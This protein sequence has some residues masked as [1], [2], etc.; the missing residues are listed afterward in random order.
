MAERIDAHK[1]KER[2]A[3]GLKRLASDRS[4]CPRN[5]QLIADFL[6]DGELGKT[7]KRRAKKKL[8]PARCIKYLDTLRLLGAW[9]EKPFDEATQKDMEVLILK[10]EHDD[11]CRKDGR[12]YTAQTKVDFK[13]ALRKFY[14]WLW[15]NNETTPEIVSWFDTHVAV[16][17][18]PAL[19]R[20]EI[21]SM[22][23]HT[24]GSREKAALMVLFD[25]GARAE[26]FLNI[27]LQHVT[28][29]DSYYVLRI[30]HSKTKPRT[31]SVPMC[32]Q[33]LDDWLQEHPEPDNQD[34]QLF[35]F[36]YPA[37]RMCVVR[38]GKRVLGKHVTPHLLRHTSATYYCNKL[39]AYQLC[40]RYG[41]SMNSDQPA[42][43]IDRAGVHERETA[44]IVQA[45][46][47]GRVREENRKLREDMSMLQ[48]EHES[49]KKMMEKIERVMR[50]MMEDER[51]RREIAVAAN[52]LG[53][54]EAVK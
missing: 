46:E 31:I 54:A 1:V 53:L 9:L 36:T 47:T 45:D 42:R 12:P 21:Q 19:T 27:R 11:F 13:K 16:P 15:G 33:L 30:E 20:A 26:E 38:T 4:L 18:I 44:K 43:Y 6:R 22:V 35:P 10:L 14:K 25:A 34:A 49:L 51:T 3:A 28:R 41:W 39:T 2:Y 5:R 32:T 29:E 40:Y 48:M 52:R 17:E 24:S 8:G 37:L 23:A 7:V 50:P